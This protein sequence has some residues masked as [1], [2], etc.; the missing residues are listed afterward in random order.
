MSNSLEWGF[1]SWLLKKVA[2]NF[3][4]RFQYFIN[5]DFLSTNAYQC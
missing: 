5:E 2:N 3:K 1:D 4:T